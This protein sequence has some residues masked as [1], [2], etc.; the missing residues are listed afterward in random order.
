MQGDEVEHLRQIL[1]QHG[2]ESGLKELIGIAE[3]T[4]EEFEQRVSATCD[5]KYLEDWNFPIEIPADNLELPLIKRLCEINPTM[6][7]PQSDPTSYDNNPTL[8]RNIIQK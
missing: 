3:Q 5:A 6:Q 2:I 7:L 1:K 8:I 4:G